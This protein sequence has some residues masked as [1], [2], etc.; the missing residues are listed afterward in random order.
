MKNGRPVFDEQYVKEWDDIMVYPP[1]IDPADV[2]VG[3]IRYWLAEKPQ[4]DT[5][6]KMWN[7]QDAGY[8]DT[9]MEGFE[10]FPCDSFYAPRLEHSF[11]TFA[12]FGV[13]PYWCEYA[14]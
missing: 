5:Y 14:K 11:P 2:V 8:F 1:G 3:R 7:E 4:L 6:E 13:K 9:P 12:I 10:I